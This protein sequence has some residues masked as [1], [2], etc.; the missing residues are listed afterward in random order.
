MAKDI[1]ERVDYFFSTF[2]SSCKVDEVNDAEYSIG[3][4]TRN[5]LLVEQELTWY[6]VP[7]ITFW[8]VFSCSAASAAL[9]LNNSSLYPGICS[10]L[11][12]DGFTVRF[13]EKKLIGSAS[14][15]CRMQ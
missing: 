8:G 5:H 1:R 9:I 12:K 4:P 2:C 7:G 14:N 15:E 13:K 10:R 3:P 6:Q 11:L